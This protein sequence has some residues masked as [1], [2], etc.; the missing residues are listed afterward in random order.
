MENLDLT[1]P[2]LESK[3]EKGAFCPLRGFI[4]E[5]KG[6]GGNGGF[7]AP[8]YSIQDCSITFMTFINIGTFYVHKLFWMLQCNSIG[9][10]L[11]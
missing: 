2:R 5:F 6:W 11:S 1:S 4:L 3:L 9:N 10:L 7:A 8:F